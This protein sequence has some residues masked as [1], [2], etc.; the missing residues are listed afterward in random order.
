APPEAPT[1]P[2]RPTI[3][4]AWTQPAGGV[5]AA[6]PP[7]SHGTPSLQFAAVDDGDPAAFTF[8]PLVD[9]AELQ[10]MPDASMGD[11]DTDWPALRTVPWISP[12]Q[13]SATALKAAIKED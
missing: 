11:G 4:A 13:G 3:I 6:A 2:A 1:A 12:I 8:R 9:H 10:P 7:V 5:L